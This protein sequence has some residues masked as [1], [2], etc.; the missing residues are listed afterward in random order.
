[1]M[2][3]V[4]ALLICVLTSLLTKGI[5]MPVG[6]TNEIDG[7]LPTWMGGF[8]WFPDSLSIK[9]ALGLIQ[10]MADLLKENAKQVL[11]GVNDV[12]AEILVGHK[13]KKLPPCEAV[14]GR[15]KQDAAAGNVTLDAAAAGGNVTLDA[16]AAGGNVT[17][18]AAAAGGN[19]T[20]DEAAAGGNVTLDEAAAGGNVT[21]DEA[22][23]GGN[24]TLDEAAAGGNVTLDEAAAGGNVTLDEAAAG[25]NVTLDEAAAGGNVT[26]DEAAAGGNVTL[27]E[28]AAGGNVTLDEAAAGGN[29]RIERSTEPVD[30]ATEGEY[31]KA[32]RGGRGDS[33]SFGNLGLTPLR[34]HQVPLH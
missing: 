32:V 17:L 19:V 31:F 9:K 10:T 34:Q 30:E 7:V 12:E 15:L 1:M 11:V 13:L 5:C 33:P 29:V 3:A 14:G 26:L 20:L 27:D 25:G 22:A 28:A 16:A 6:D 21:L 18:D 4:R 23:A 8:E 2:G 24:V